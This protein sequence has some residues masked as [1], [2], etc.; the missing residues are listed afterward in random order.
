[1]SAGRILAIDYGEKNIGLALSDEMR[2]IAQGLE[3]IVNRG[4]KTFESIRILV[5][6][7][8]VSEVVVGWPLNMNGTKSQKT[9][10]VEK[11]CLELE[12]CIPV[13]V[14]KSDERLT[15][16]QAERMLIDGG[17]SRKKR[18]KVND[19]IAAQLILQNYLALKKNLDRNAE[20]GR[21]TDNK[22]MENS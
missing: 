3:S 14:A 11:F 17:M 16:R 18:K 5:E 12:K 20:E 2:I 19:K 10:E 15:S 13:P 22:D 7:N 9:L 21:R 4:S 6:K 1:M 8:A